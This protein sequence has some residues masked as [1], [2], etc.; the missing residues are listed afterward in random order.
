MVVFMLSALGIPVDEDELQK[1][2]NEEYR[3]FGDIVQVPY[4]NHSHVST[5]RIESK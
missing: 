1:K 4:N 5:I 3:E 2:I